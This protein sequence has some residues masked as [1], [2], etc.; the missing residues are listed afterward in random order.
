MVALLKHQEE[1]SLEPLDWEVAGEPIH[2]MYQC[3]KVC[4]GLVF[5]IEL[6]FY[7]HLIRPIVAPLS[8]YIGYYY[9]ALKRKKRLKMYNMRTDC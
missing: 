4:L 5:I 1:D 8:L 6:G 3:L 2:N 7:K 9:K